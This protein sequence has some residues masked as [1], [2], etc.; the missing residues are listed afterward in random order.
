MPGDRWIKPVL[1]DIRARGRWRSLD[2]RIVSGKQGRHVDIAGRRLLCFASNDYLGL[3]GDDVT[4]H[5]AAA[6]LVLWGHGAG[7]S[8]HIS[9][10]MAPH[11]ALEG[12]LASWLRADTAV[13]FGSGVLAN[14][15]VIPAL[16]GPGDAV[17]SDEL[18]HAS[19]VDGCRLARATTHVYRHGDAAHLSTLLAAHPA[20]RRLVVTDALFSMDGD[21]A[22]LPEIAAVVQEHDVMLLVDEAHA[23]GTLGQ[24][25]GACVEA[26]V[27]D[28]VTVRIGTLGKALGSYGAFA[29]G[30][31]AV[32]DLLT[33]RARSLVFSTALPPSACAAALAALDVVRHGE[34][35]QKLR[36]LCRVA[37][38]AAVRHGVAH[39]LPRHALAG[40]IFPLIV[41]EDRAALRLADA[42][43]ARGF[44]GVGVRPPTVPDGTARVR[45]TLSALHHETDVEALFAAVATSLAEGR[46]TLAEAG[47]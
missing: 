5:A 31:R 12:Q 4:S 38:E 17:F 3:A 36:H 26:G 1:D 43:R 15:G 11:V 30:S 32:V 13:L 14:T 45:I 46:N 7:A 8:R 35:T 9:G 40:P 39:L 33:N 20:P 10:N 2:H 27:D 6:A 18:N 22:P 47:A 41:G 42:L 25:R 28:V 29:C 23:I 37:Q 21:L 34:R 16:V 19:I 24:G 44:L